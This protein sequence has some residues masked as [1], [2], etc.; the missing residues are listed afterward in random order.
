MRDALALAFGTLT[1]WPVPPPRRV[2]QQ[3]AGSAI[4]LAP[5]TQLPLLGL[6]A[7]GVLGWRALDGPPS[8]AAVGLIAMLALSTRAMH[9]DGLA[10]TADGLTSSYDRERS[11]AVMRV[12]DIGPAGVA[13][14]VLVLL[15]QA[16]SLTALLAGGGVAASLLA[17]VAVLASR[18]ALSGACSRGVP[19]ADASGL[20]ATV[21][22]SVRRAPLLGSAIALV[23]FSLLPALAGAG[24]WAGPIVVLGAWAA[25]AAVVLRAHR[26]LGGI[27]GDILGAVIEIALATALALATVVS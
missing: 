18:Q 23:S 12:G 24:W 8:V 4:L 11:L 2:D 20:G 3:V 7:L 15:I 13:A 26:R 22:G 5:V 25:A 10:D 6:S 9:L 21:A 16:A 17:I 19:A 27:T 14:V 1:A